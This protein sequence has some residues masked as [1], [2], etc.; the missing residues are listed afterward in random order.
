MSDFRISGRSDSEI[1]NEIEQIMSSAESE[2]GSWDTLWD[3]VTRYFY[4]HQ[5]DPLEEMQGSRRRE[6][7][8]DSTG[9]RN[10]IRLS[11]AL[12]NFVSPPDQPW[13]FLD[14]PFEEFPEG[15]DELDWYSEAGRALLFLFSN[16]MGG[17]AN[18]IF[19]T[20]LGIVT[21]GS[22]AIMM[23]PHETDV[24][25]FSSH[26][27]RELYP[28]YD[29]WGN[30]NVMVRQFRFTANE[31]ASK[32]G[33]E[34]ISED[35][36]KDIA[37]KAGHTQQREYLHLL[38]NNA[39][40][41]P[42]FDGPENKRV[43]SVYV[44]RGSQ[45]VVSRGGFDQMPVAMGHWVRQP[46]ESYGRSP[47][48]S[49]LTEAI[50]ST[51]GRRIDLRARAKIADPPLLMPF[52]GVMRNT[53]L[54]RINPG[55]IIP[56]RST[57]ARPEPVPTGNPGAMDALMNRWEAA[58]NHAFFMD[59]LPPIPQRDRTTATEFVTRMQGARV[60]LSP[61][62]TSIQQTLLT[63]I[64]MMSLKELVKK[65]VLRVPPES[66][67]PVGPESVRV[68]YTS[69]LS[70]SQSSPEVQ[71]IEGLLDFVS[72]VVAIDPQAQ[73]AINGDGMVRIYAKN[74]KVP[75][76]AVN[77]EEDARQIRDGQAQQQALLDQAKAAQG[78][79]AGIG[80][81]VNATRPR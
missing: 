13:S 38:A 45:K 30:V 78:F 34:N 46:R 36:K 31:A 41:L 35:A 50:Q 59:V 49:V 10:S 55:Q 3:L 15:S 63:P 43:L 65:K 27:V 76:E 4:P 44:D 5:T 19:Q 25:R 17:F 48:I 66:I 28:G 72:R 26:H 7:V 18:S 29:D 32:W 6:R 73:S 74:A 79:G 21:F 39:E 22:Q 37:N 9:E 60:V 70:A 40:F 54:G 71:S 1:T 61:F 77:V 58:I 16:T 33:I 42:R 8:L 68:S 14:H 2:R 81:V 11:G 57:M 69:P 12:Y 53:S 23:S 47:A 75:S 67:G 51:S 62:V 64:V 56:Y 80:D 52:S 24:A 20:Y